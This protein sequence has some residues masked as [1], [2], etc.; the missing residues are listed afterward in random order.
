METDSIMGRLNSQTSPAE[1]CDGDGTATNELTRIEQ[2]IRGEDDELFARANAARGKH[3]GEAVHLRGI[4]EFS[5]V[6]SRNCAYCG[7]RRDNTAL[8]RY[9]MSPSEILAVISES[10]KHGVRTIVLQ[11]GESDS[12]N[13][14]QLAEL[15]AAVKR[16]FDVAVTLCVGAKSFEFFR[17]WR[18][19]GA[20]RYLLKHETAVPA[21]YGKFHPDST[22]EDRLS[23]L[24]RLRKLDYQ[25]GSGCII[26]IP[27]QTPA[28]LAS[29]IV[30]TDQLDADMAAFGPF[31]SHPNT[32]LSH[33]RNGGVELSLR[34]VA[35]ARLA[36]GP[37][38]IP[39]TTAFD[40]I[41]PDGRE[42]ALRAGA[43]VIM[44]NLTPEHYRPLYDIYPSNRLA[45]TID[46]VKRIL[47]RID[48]PL[49]KDHGHSLKGAKAVKSTSERDEKGKT[50]QTEVTMIPR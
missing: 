25:I 39:A 4:I 5:N 11:S 44:A 31:V 28:D 41:D 43:N 22:L 6:C 40:A 46:R 23:G 30:L 35:A 26:G 3:C 32:P 2:V 15:I 13:A 45:N 14:D 37:V 47:E 50:Q 17:R 1:C 38:H 24:A 48:R 10:A 33:V 19:A 49:A 18:E 12:E 42:Q 34:V 29:D 27:G 16:E 36:L 9:T 20:D 7:L 21:L 8:H